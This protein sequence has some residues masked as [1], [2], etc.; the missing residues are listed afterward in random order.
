M[1]WAPRGASSPQTSRT[2]ASGGTS[3]PSRRA[4]AARTERGLR[5]PTSTVAAGSSA[6]ATWLVPSTRT[7]TRSNR[8]AD[9]GPSRSGVRL[10]S[11]R[12]IVLAPPAEESPWKHTGTSPSHR[13]QLTLP[14]QA[15]PPRVRTTR[16]ACTSCTTPCAATSTGSPPPCE[17]TP[18]RRAP[19]CGPRCERR[20]VAMADV[21][22]HHHSVE[23]DELWPLL[24]R[25]A[26]AAGDAEDLA[27]ARRHGGR[28][29]RHRP[30]A[31]EACG[32]LRLDER[33]PVHRSPQRA[34][35]PARSRPRA[36]AVAPGPRGGAGPARCCSGA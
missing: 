5:A 26:E 25:H 4:S 14:G 28:A 2:S 31:R 12:E 36:P 13:P 1:P 7:H 23:D 6:S 34:G 19:R 15:T 22:H 27:G 35:D 18:D 32:R 16:P 3:L 33:A 9:S 29:R 17:G 20:W 11:R 8:S 24:Q 30:R 10:K 21:L